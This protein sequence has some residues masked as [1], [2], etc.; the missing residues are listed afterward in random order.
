[1]KALRS[2]VDNKGPVRV[3]ITICSGPVTSGRVPGRSDLVGLTCPSS[4]TTGRVPGRSD[5][6]GL[7]CP[8]SV[9]SGRVPGR[10]DLVGLTC[11][12]SVTT[13]RVPGRYC[14]VGLTCPSS[15]TT[16]RVP[17]R[18]CLVGLTCSSSVTTGTVFEGAVLPNQIVWSR[19][20]S[21]SPRQHRYSPGKRDSCQT[22]LSFRGQHHHL[23]WSRHSGRVLRK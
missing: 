4:V 17:G 1:M 7:T 10:S 22:K 16:G 3:N 14:L 15:V 2:P 5:L 9:T 18:S 12:S 23:F 13:G 19:S 8:S 21:P 20:T 6:V 11:P